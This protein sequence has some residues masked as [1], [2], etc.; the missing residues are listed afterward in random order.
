LG[1]EE[2]IAGKRSK[3]EESSEKKEEKGVE[4][5]PTWHYI[6]IRISFGPYVGILMDYF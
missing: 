5:R 1:G 4:P 6:V 3:A 2:P